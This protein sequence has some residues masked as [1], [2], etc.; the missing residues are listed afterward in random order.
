M[1]QKCTWSWWHYKVSS[2][3]DDAS[4]IWFIP[5]DKGEKNHISFYKAN[6]NYLLPKLDQEKKKYND[7]I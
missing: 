4:I 7:E 6:I 3:E 5:E 1:P 2:L